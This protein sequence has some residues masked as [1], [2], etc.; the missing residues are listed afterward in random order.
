MSFNRSRRRLADDDS[1]GSLRLRMRCGRLPRLIRKDP[2]G[3]L[4][5]REPDEIYQAMD[6]DPPLPDAS[7]D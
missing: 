1:W 5:L 4:E 6:A 2:S 7:C 3:E